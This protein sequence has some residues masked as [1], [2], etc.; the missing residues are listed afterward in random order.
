M[1]AETENTSHGNTTRRGFLAAGPSLLLARRRAAAAAA[2]PNILYI[3]TDQQH[4]G[5]MSCAGNRRLKTPAM[6]SIAATGTR[7]DLAYSANPVCV[8]ARTSMM[9]G[10]YPSYFGM[11]SNQPPG[12]PPRDLSQTLGNLFREAGYRTVFGG[13]THWPRPMTPES[14]GFEYLTADERDE[15][16]ARCAEFLGRKQDRPF[17][18]VASFINPHDICYMAIDAYTRAKNLPAMYPQS[19]VERQRVAEA[20]ALPPGVSRQEFFA[21]LCPPL[22]G[23]HGPTLGEPGAFAGFG[24]FRG[25]VRRHW[26]EEEWRLHRWA[27]CRLTERV[28]AEIARVL[29]ALRRSGL[30]RGTLVV[31]SSDHGDMDAAHGFEH[32]SLPYEE[33][34]RVPFIVSWPGH[35]AQG[36]VDRRHLVSAGVDLLPTL[37]DYAGIPAPAGL[38]GRSVRP[39]ASGRPAAGWRRDLLIEFT[40]GRCLRSRRYKYARFEGPEPRELLLDMQKDPGEMKNLAFEPSLAS[41]LAGHRERLR[42]SIGQPGG[43]ADQAA[44]RLRGVA[45]PHVR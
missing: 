29:E 42:Q 41:V 4:A 15:L 45:H 11:E 3:M 1:K 22:P 40:G 23:N 35:A 37:C 33:A 2:R 38:P 36:R 7:F 39:L 27:Y 10:R 9:T 8:P 17:L 5:M 34:A 16:A 43:P 26:S 28:D 21:R 18:L 14:L 20:A 13:K 25:Y 31:F 44:Q 32:K 12:H 19:T 30:D 24:S 6:D